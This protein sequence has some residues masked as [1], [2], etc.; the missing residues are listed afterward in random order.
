LSIEPIK[1]G[2]LVES[3]LTLVG[4][5]LAEQCIELNNRLEESQ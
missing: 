4:S 5:G 1:V 2:E 3:R